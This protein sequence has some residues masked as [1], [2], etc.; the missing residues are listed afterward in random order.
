MQQYSLLECAD[1]VA[2]PASLQTQEELAVSESD[3]E[4]MRKK[5][6]TVGGSV[7]G[8]VGMAQCHTMLVGPTMAWCSAEWAR[9]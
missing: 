5:C 4:E 6:F 3:Y 8:W 2:A 9:H 1:S 7:R